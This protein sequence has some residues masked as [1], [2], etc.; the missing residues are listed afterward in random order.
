MKRQ[1]LFK[2][3]LALV[4]LFA[5]INFLTSCS[6][7]NETAVTPAV[8]STIS[9]LAEAT[10]TLSTLVTA[11]RRTG[12]DLYPTLDA[13]GTYTVFAPSNAA[14]ATFFASISPPNG[15]PVTVDNILA[16]TLKQVLLNHVLAKQF[17]SVAATGSTV[18]T[19]GYVKTLA[20][21]GGGATGNPLSM[22]LNTA[23][24]VRVNG[25]SSVTLANLIASNGV[26]HIVDAVIGL[27]TIVTHA[28]AN[29]DFSTLVA[30]LSST[31][32]PTGAAS[33]VTV[34]SGPGPFT[35]FAPTNTAFTTALAAGAWANGAMPAQITKVLQYHVTTAG[36]VLSTAL[37][38]GQVIP[39]I[40]MPVLNTTVD[41][42]GGVKI[43]DTQNLSA[44]VIAADVQ[45]SNGVIHGVDK[46]LRPF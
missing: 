26:V 12:V 45:C 24:G 3:I 23:S 30:T 7:D 20:T 34:L 37:T 6:L 14:F 8:R 46:V 28:A 41:L 32:Q 31:G 36:N 1:N 35:V 22:Y 11:L 29:P 44:T 25:V 16:A 39:M 2:K 18:I 40:T 43:K 9:K 21:F 4:L 33:F 27:P 13:A 19:T 10:P 38:Q 42:V 15:P 17:T 5:S